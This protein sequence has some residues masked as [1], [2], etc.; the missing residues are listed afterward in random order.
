ML[1]L[2]TNLATISALRLKI[3]WVSL[4]ILLLLLLFLLLPKPDARLPSKSTVKQ[5]K[6]PGFRLL[7]S[8]SASDTARHPI[9]LCCFLR[10]P[11]K[12]TKKLRFK[13]EHRY[14]S[15]EA[16]HMHLTNMQIK[17]LL[18]V[19][20]SWV[21]TWLILILQLGYDIWN[22]NIKAKQNITPDRE[23]SQMCDRWGD[24]TTKAGKTSL[25]FSSQVHIFLSTP[26]CCIQEHPGNQQV[27]V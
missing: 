21:C 7:K 17:S 8:K 4:Q 16:S 2:C 11:E 24:K 1:K 14:A 26:T 12:D 10:L 27:H 5:L 18:W 23:G 3:V 20:V 19:A 9:P 15:R 6:Y 22:E 13:G 25:H